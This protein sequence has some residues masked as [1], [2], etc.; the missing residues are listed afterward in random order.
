MLVP[1]S[2]LTQP[3][4]RRHLHAEVVDGEGVLLV[5]DGYSA[6]LGGRLFERLTPLLDGSLETDAVVDRLAVDASRPEV[7]Y[8]L[9]LLQERGYLEEADTALPD[10]EAAYWGAQGL[11]ARTVANRLATTTVSV[12]EVGDVDG[13]PLRALLERAGARLVAAGGDLRVVLADDYLREELSATNREALA[14][15]GPWMLAKPVGAQVWIG[16]VLRPGAT[17]CWTC[18][19]E[20]LRGRRAIDRSAPQ[21]ATAASRAA[22]DGLLAA[23]VA[24]WVARGGGSE[25]DG[26]ILSLDLA[27]GRTRTHPLLR[28]PGCPDCG[29]S[30]ALRERPAEPLVPRSRPKR[31]TAD[32]GHRTRRP[33]ETLER[34]GHHLSEITGLGGEL[35]RCDVGDSEGIVNV[36]VAADRP[37][38]A[39]RVR[40]RSASSGKGVTDLQ[41]RASALGESIERYS[42]VYQGCERRLK[43]CRSE[44][45]DA[46]LDPRAVMQFSDRQYRDRERWN[47]RGSRFDVVPVPLDDAAELDSEMPCG[48]SHTT[49]RDTCRRVSATTASRP[50]PRGRTSARART[51]A[52]PATRSRRRSFRASSSWPSATR[53]G[54]GGTTGCRARRSRSTA[55][56]IPIPSGCGRSSPS[57]GATCGR[58]T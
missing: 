33:E 40:G 32:G 19:A 37:G 50:T 14:R 8:A 9:H 47:A 7:L 44:L 43:A 26:Q 22:A 13:D 55:S 24:G 45:G 41:A 29:A 31:F 58:S 3:R 11:D 57:A 30:A 17:A 27:S 34:F 1:L 54:S 39:A 28:R 16:P 18:L 21:G 52:R 53:S 4:L 23:Q 48:R 49:S 46:A 38:G 20:P 56:G 51:A 36:Y 6:R 15:G 42:G 10:G 25:L 12:A 2:R 35:R 5:A